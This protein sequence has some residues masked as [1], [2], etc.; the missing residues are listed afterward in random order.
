[1]LLRKQ[2]IFFF[3]LILCTSHLCAQTPCTTLG[4]NP[5][6]AFPVCGTA[7]FHQA[8][9]PICSS[10]TL[11]VPGCSVWGDPNS[12]YQNKNP[13]W[14]KFTCFQAGTLH[15]L[16][17][18]NDPNE[19]YDWQLYD[20]TGHNPDDV[21][22]DTS[23]I[24]TGNWAGTYGLTGAND[25]GLNYIACASLP[26]L[27]ISTFALSPNLIQGH[28]YILLVSHFS[29]TQ[30][31]YSLS[32]GGGTAVI[33]D[34]IPP[35]LVNANRASCDGSRIMVKLN[36]KMK[37]NTVAVNGTDFMIN[38]P[39]ANIVSAVAYGCSNG[40]DTDSVLLTF[41]QPLPF[42]NYNLV[43][44]EGSDLNTILDIC[45]T[46][47]PVGEVLPFSVL[48]LQPVPL[49]SL[50]HNKCSTD[51]LILVLPD[52]V[53]CGSVAANGSDFI[54]T[55]TY[56]VSILRAIPADCANGLTTRIILHLGA[57]MVQPGTFQVVLRKG[58]D[59]NTLLSKCDTPSVV[60]DFVLFNILPKPV[61]DFS[62]PASLC[63]PN[64]TANFVNLSTISDG[65]GNLLQYLW[66]FGDPASTPNNTSVLKHPSHRYTS[67]GPFNVN[68]RVTSNA[69]CF[70]DT[71]VVFNNIHPQP[72]TNFGFS[73]PAICI[74]DLITMTDSTNAMD[75][76]TI[77]WNWA[78]G[79]GSVRNIKSF[80]YTYASVQ[81][82]TVTL[83]TI[84]SH[85]CFSDTVS[86]TITVHP[87]PTVNAGPDRILLSGG[88]ITIEAQATGAV[89]QYLW[90]PSTYLNNTTV[91]NPRCIAPQNDITYTL[92][93]T[94]AGGCAASDDMFVKVLKVPRIP[95]VFTP[96]NDGINDR[97][98]IQYLED[99]PNNHL[100]VFTRA[101][102][103]VYESRG[104]Y[105]PWNGTYKGKPLP[106]DTYY[107][108]LEPGYGR[109]NMSGFVAIIR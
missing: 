96:N 15:F 67:T 17:T 84:N 11:Y 62:V 37:C 19:D 13:F 87:Y 90:T 101:G 63:L 53:Q 8:D 30:Q 27:L 88:Q 59:G 57:L 105:K 49:D 98:V 102:Q 106:Y 18:P 45:D 54:I 29:D 74:G 1:M 4:Q 75:G 79:D 94:N 91:L 107:Y 6:T 39:L 78:L 85:G 77:F 70:K 109:E 65:T 32:F 82:F 21:Y 100:Q 93:V 5:S 56:P 83:Y 86:K 73:K 64:A 14:Y 60:G 103:L 108:I 47:I 40:F 61:A 12:L 7:T 44:K 76:T 72:K 34:T 20:I 25:T 69:G 16:I 71:T 22:T 55:G 68:L 89:L 33:T 36:K 9:V 10:N 43:V 38:P 35:H 23:L 80:S 24:V 46:G 95:N 104:T 58:T 41:N 99:Y 52:S 42:G 66:D 81:T 26:E 31:G 97:W 51:S 28:D 3:L 48:S 92:T 50:Q 2:A